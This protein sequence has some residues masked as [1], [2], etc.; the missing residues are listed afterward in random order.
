MTWFF[1]NGARRREETLSAYIDG[2]LAPSERAKVQRLLESSA[3]WRQ[4]FEMLQA[5]IARVR[6]APRV[7]ARR[8]FAL[9]PEMAGARTQATRQPAAF[10]RPVMSLATAAA[11]V[12]LA[13]SLAG[14]AGLFGT[15]PQA[16]TT[17]GSS[18]SDQ[19]AAP[20][21]Q[22][23][24]AGAPAAAPAPQAQLKAARSAE[25]TQ[26]SAATPTATTAFT[27]GTTERT[28]AQEGPAGPG[29]PATL[30]V[31]TRNSGPP[32]WT[33]MAIASGAAATLFGITTFWM[34]RRARRMP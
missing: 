24:A 20:T 32:P 34:F 6:A 5:A 1:K 3:E 2:R 29:G 19:F 23:P 26:D 8:S 18:A 16:V 12:V 22:P 28:M 10:L 30:S 4:E 33:A 31:T 25:S 7:Q 9:T 17:S 11:S 13:V 21:A 27:Y 15:A 14:G